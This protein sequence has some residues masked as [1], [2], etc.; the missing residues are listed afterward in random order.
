VSR[1]DFSNATRRRPPKDNDRLLEGEEEFV[2]LEIFVES[3]FFDFGHKLFS[4][5]LCE[6]AGTALLSVVVVR[7]RSYVLAAQTLGPKVQ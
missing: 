1:R 2:T 7:P 4:L 3:D 6:A 5:T